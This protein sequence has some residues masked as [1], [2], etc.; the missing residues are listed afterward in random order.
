[1]SVT[2]AIIIAT[3]AV[4]MVAFPRHIQ[5]IDSMRKPEL[6]N[7]LKFNAYMIYHRKE[8]YRM[9]SAGLLHANWSHL[10]F[11]MITLFFFGRNVEAAF[12]VLFGKFGVLIF[13]TF[14]A[15]ALGVSSIYDLF[16]YKDSHYYNAIGA[17]GAVSA[18]LFAAIFLDP[19]MSLFIM[20]IPIPIPALLFGPVYLYYSYY[21]GKKQMDNIGHNA[22][23]WG[24][25]FGF[26]FPAI[27]KPILIIV[28]IKQVM[29]VF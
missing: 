14:Y 6:F 8:W 19:G 29:N 2:I 5:S 20:F 11:N 17:S 9:F 16:K 1:M 24:A 4:S 28:F 18:V 15:L 12:E 25:V 22:H 7:K 10:A 21:M 26:I 23:F 27:L 13:I 3:V